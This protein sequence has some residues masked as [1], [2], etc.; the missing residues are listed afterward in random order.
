MA[1]ITYG[2]IITDIKGSLGGTTYQANS[3]GKI[4]RSKPYTPVNP[5]SFQTDRQTMLASLVSK[6][7]LLSAAN[8][9]LW[10]ALA[11][12]HQHTDA[13]GVT[14]FL[15]GYQWFLSYNLNCV[16]SNQA[17]Q[18]FPQGFV[19]VAPCSQFTANIYSNYLT[20]NWAAPESFPGSYAFIYATPPL[21]QNNVNIKKS[22]FFIKLWDTSTV[23][24]ID[25]TTW[26]EAAF[27][28]SLASLVAS[29]NCSI[30][31]RLKNMSEDTGYVSAF[32]SAVV[33]L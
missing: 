13:W 1:R 33:Q 10:N 28:V 20:I 6:W 23:T 26:Y 29:S 16:N 25:V 7:S 12:A 18:L 24:Y 30:V 2:S 22:L 27:G 8:K 5:S 11:A 21:R 14:K 19:S 31:L 15:S 17:V 32:T 4:G 9:G 3:S